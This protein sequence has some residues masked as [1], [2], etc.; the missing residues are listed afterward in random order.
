M[1]GKEINE[2]ERKKVRK[3]IGEMKERRKEGK[4]REGKKEMREGKSTNYREKSVVW[5]S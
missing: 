3:D 1:L 2:K 5:L 4:R